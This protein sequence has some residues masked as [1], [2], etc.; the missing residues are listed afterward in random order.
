M[1]EKFNFDIKTEQYYFGNLDKSNNKYYFLDTEARYVVKKNKLTFS[2]NGNNLLNTKTFRNYN[3][4]DI[5]I[6]K[7]EYRLQNRYVL[8]KME[9]R[10]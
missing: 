9:L 2:L 5:D 8:L 7:T 6:S 4:S 1:N 10:F 3:I